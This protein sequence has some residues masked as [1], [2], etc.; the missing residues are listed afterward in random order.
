MLYVESEIQHGVGLVILRSQSN[1]II[2]EPGR[3]SN[4]QAASFLERPGRPPI[5]MAKI[6]SRKPVRIAMFKPPKSIT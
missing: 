2:L 1:V 3:T 4:Y 5:A 6:V